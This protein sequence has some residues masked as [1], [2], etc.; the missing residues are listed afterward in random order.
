M[1][2]D[3]STNAFS[4]ETVKSLEIHSLVS[5]CLSVML[6]HFPVWTMRTLMLF[7]PT[8]VGP[9]GPR[10]FLGFLCSQNR[11]FKDLEAATLGPTG[12]LCPGEQGLRTRGSA[13]GPLHCHP[14]SSVRAQDGGDRSLA[15]SGTV[16]PPLPHTPESDST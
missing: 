10:L 13:C 2:S 4:S 11:S 8:Q 5:K 1:E 16:T 14:P 12:F 3:L 6:L 9:P 7:L 15:A